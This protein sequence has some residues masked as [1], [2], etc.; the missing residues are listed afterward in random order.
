MENQIVCPKCNKT[1]SNT[2]LINEAANG[3][4][5]FTQYMRC[6]CGE[7]LTYWQIT[8][9]LNK[10]RTIGRRFKNWFRSF[11]HSRS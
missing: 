2:A 9:Q 10:Q 6:E 5:A 3:E 7:R 4:G 11:S 1:T 8:A